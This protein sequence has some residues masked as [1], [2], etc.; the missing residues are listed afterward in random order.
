MRRAV[1]STP[2]TIASTLSPTLRIFEGCLTRLLHD[3]SLT[4]MSPSTPASSS[5]NAP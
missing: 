4:W 1:G 3:I 5:T 2:S